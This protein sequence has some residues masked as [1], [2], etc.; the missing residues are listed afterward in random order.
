MLSALILGLT[1][2]SP[3]LPRC[4]AIGRTARTMIAARRKGVDEATALATIDRELSGDARRIARTLA[5]YIYEAN[6]DGRLPAA[7]LLDQVDQACRSTERNALSG[8]V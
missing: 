2:A 4:A 8:G 1:L 6:A 7:K 3:P 5:W